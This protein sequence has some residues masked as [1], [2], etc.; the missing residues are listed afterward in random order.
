MK[1]VKF[2]EDFPKLKDKCFTTIRLS[3]KK[4]ETGRIYLIKTPTTEFKATLSHQ[5]KVKLYEIPDKLLAYDTGMGSPIKAFCKL[6]EFYP[7]LKATDYVRMFWFC[8]EVI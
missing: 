6:Q 1:T 8:K 5:I 7:E 4:L 2:A 3:S